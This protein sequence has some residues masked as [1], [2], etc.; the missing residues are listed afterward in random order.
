M[1]PLTYKILTPSGDWKSYKNLK[2]GDKILAYSDG[3]LIPQEITSITKTGVSDM[4]RLY[5]FSNKDGFNFF[6]DQ[7]NDILISSLKKAIRLFLPAGF[8]FDSTFPI[9]VAAPPELK[10]VLTYEGVLSDEQIELLTYLMAAGTCNEGKII[11]A[12]KANSN[13]ADRLEELCDELVIRY[14]KKKG[15]D[16]GKE[17]PVYYQL[18]EN[19]QLKAIRKHCRFYRPDDCEP[20]FVEW[21]LHKKY[22]DLLAFETCPNFVTSLTVRQANLVLNTWLSIAGKASDYW[23]LETKLPYGEAMLAYF[24]VITGRSVSFTDG[25]VYLFNRTTRECKVQIVDSESSDVKEV[26][27]VSLAGDKQASKCC[28]LTDEGWTFWTDIKTNG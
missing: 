7:T 8:S 22:E 1:I 5:H 27:G 2:A 18:V 9:T 4:Q 23:E 28:I 13:A 15:D 16:F 10:Q 17:T 25:K 3:K 24:G 21:D 11:V 14:I 19:K 26:W 20:K 6:V 12:L